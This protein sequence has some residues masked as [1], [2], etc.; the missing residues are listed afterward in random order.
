MICSEYKPTS[1]Y[2]SA[3][4][5]AVRRHEG[6][7]FACREQHQNRP[8]CLA[9]K[10]GELDLAGGI[11]NAVTKRLHAMPWPDDVCCCANHRRTHIQVAALAFFSPKEP[12]VSEICSVLGVETPPNILVKLELFVGG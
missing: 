12:V 1:S 10:Q 4:N 2:R 7:G 9:V 8:A 11:R 6:A 3:E 5:R